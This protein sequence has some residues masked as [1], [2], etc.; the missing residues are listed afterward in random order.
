MNLIEIVINHDLNGLKD[1]LKFSNINVCDTHK[2]SLLHLAV[3]NNDA[4][5][6][7]YLILNSIDINRENE[8]GNTPLHFSILFNRLGIFKHIIKS[9]A[10]INYQNK[11]LES[12]LMLALRLG[13]STMAKILLELDADTSFEN[14]HGEGYPF[15]ALYDDDIFKL[16]L[17]EINPL[18]YVN[19]N[20]DS[21]LHKASAINKTEIVKFFSLKYHMLI[22][23]KNKEGETPLFVALK[24]SNLESAFIMIKQHALIDISNIYSEQIM[25]KLNDKTK[26]IVQSMLDEPEYQRYLREYPLQVAVIKNDGFEVKRLKSIIRKNKRDI[27]G[28]IPLDYAKYYKFD[29]IIN[30]LNRN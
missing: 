16:A 24:R 19:K 17:K 3:F 18:V 2:N 20:G 28:Y 6:A 27:Y 8:D 21:L 10:D 23:K 15:Y 5:I 13:R 22:N 26:D 30:E 14:I 9:G 4:D 7:N 11:A 1:N 25:D 12:P 29:S